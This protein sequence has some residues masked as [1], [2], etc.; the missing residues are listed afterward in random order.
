MKDEGKTWMDK[1]EDWMAHSSL[2]VARPASRRPP[3]GSQSWEA[4]APPSHHT[5]HKIKHRRIKFGTPNLGPMLCFG[6]AYSLSRLPSRRRSC[7]DNQPVSCIALICVLFP[8]IAFWFG[9]EKL[10]VYFGFIAIVLLLNE[11]VGRLHDLAIRLSRTNELLVDGNDE[12]R[13]RKAGA[14]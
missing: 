14:S 8:G 7:R 12:R 4:F 13:Y 2:D 1:V 10:A 11:A 5:R 9:G 6:L 3:Y